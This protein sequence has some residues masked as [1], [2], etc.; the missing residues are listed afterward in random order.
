MSSKKFDIANNVSRRMSIV[1]GTMTQ[2][3]LAKRLNISPTT[4]WEYFHGRVPPADFIVRFCELFDISPTWLLTGEEK[5][6]EIEGID[7]I[8]RRILLIVK[9][10]SDE[11]KK[12]FL[13]S[14][15]KEKLLMELLEERK[16]KA[17]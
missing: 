3:E 2:R 14:L 5:K 11:Q 1:M 12:E 9:D 15:E 13:R 8:T 10:M 17:G 7:D 6:T 16:R 4:L